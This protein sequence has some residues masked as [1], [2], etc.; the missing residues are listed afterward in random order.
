MLVFNPVEYVIG[1]DFKWKMML[2]MC[3][4]QE[5]DNCLRMYEICQKQLS[6]V[7][8][9]DFKPEAVDKE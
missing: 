9:K 1:F 4:Q 7:I 2:D 3:V 5:N 6:E 8:S